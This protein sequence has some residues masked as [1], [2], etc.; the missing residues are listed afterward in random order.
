MNL[1]GL[2]GKKLGI[3]VSVGAAITAYDRA[4]KELP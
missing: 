2:R 4:K 1:A 3:L